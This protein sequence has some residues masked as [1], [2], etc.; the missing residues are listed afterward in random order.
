[1]FVR[2]KD[3]H[4]K[5]AYSTSKLELHNAMVYYDYIP[6]VSYMLM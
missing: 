4:G 1:M 3:Y 5:V 2:N 6:G